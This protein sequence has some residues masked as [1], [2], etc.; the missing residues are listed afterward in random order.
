MATGEEGRWRTYCLER[1][2]SGAT[3]IGATV[4]MPRRIRQHNGEIK[5]G[6]MYTT[7]AC[8]KGLSWNISCNVVG[9]QTNKEALSFEWHWKFQS[10]K[11][12]AGPLMR[13][14]KALPILFEKF[15][16]N[17]NL[18]ILI[19][20]NASE[21]QILHPTLSAYISHIDDYAAALLETLPASS[22]D[23][24]GMIATP[25]DLQNSLQDPEEEEQ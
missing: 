25:L 14:I 2:D 24:V 9:F 7:R 20:R 12:N 10:R 19:Y 4:N 16:T 23:E 8:K 17:G 1:S 22:L 11:I 21:F 5:G 18:T 15:N 6:A 13:R 3:Y